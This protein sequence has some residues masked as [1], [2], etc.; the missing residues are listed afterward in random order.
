MTVLT[1]SNAFPGAPFPQH[2]SGQTTTVQN[3]RYPGAVQPIST[4]PTILSYTNAFPAAAFPQHS[5]G[6]TTTVKNYLF[7]GAVQPIVASGAV[8]EAAGY[9]IF[10]IRSN[11]WR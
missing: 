5:S 1:P 10:R 11:P 2:G 9:M 8:V 3:Y 7:P 4:T 6:Q